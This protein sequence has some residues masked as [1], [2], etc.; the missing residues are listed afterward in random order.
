[1]S[2]KKVLISSTIANIFEWYDYAL[3]GSFATLIG[4]KFFPESNPKLEILN[5][6]LV[7][8]VGYLMRPIGG[9]FFGIIGDKFGRR[10][11]LSL[12]VICMS[13]PTAAIGLIPTYETIGT[14][15]SIILCMMRMVQGLSM[16]G[17][18]TGSIS[19]LIEHTNKKNRGLVG[20]IPMASICIGILLGTMVSIIIRSSLSESDFENWGWR[21]P[22]L[23]GIFILFAGFYII[24]YTE[25][26]P[27]FKEAQE[28][29]KLLSAPFTT[30]IKN[31]SFDMLIS[32]FIN[33]TG[34]V[35]FYF[36][37][38]FIPNFLKVNREFSHASVDKLS[39]ISYFLMAFMCLIFGY[40]SDKLGKRRTYVFIILILMTLIFSISSNFEHG[41]WY[42][43]IFYQI[44]LGVFA[45][46][47]IAPEPALQ[48]EFYPT[49]VRS[50]ALSISYNLSTSLFGGT[51]PFVI[52][53]LYEK[54]GS[55]YGCASYIIITS[56]FSLI[57]LYFY[58]NRCT[59]VGG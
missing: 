31:H 21:I 14:T 33:S 11:S 13:L 7:F 29:G 56:L 50:T 34:S 46:A 10:F 45:A 49:N 2:N 36:Q 22:F 40:I 24:K 6:F 28:K 57:G 38:I 19:F 8:A 27:M 16:G 26:T 47:Y 9:I 32:I 59:E 17:A 58:K 23:L 51:A 55:L 54:T 48:A 12:A 5:A 4:H 3:F 35:I 20:S 25:E 1:M 39:A 37:A 53:Y 30:V 42:D 43:V 18:L 15:A 52:S 44:V 41:S